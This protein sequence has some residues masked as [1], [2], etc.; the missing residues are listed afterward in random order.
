MTNR[1]PPRASPSVPAGRLRMGDPRRLLVLFLAARDHGRHRRRRAVGRG[2][3]LGWRSVLLGLL[4]HLV[5]ALIAFGHRASMVGG[6]GWPMLRQKTAAFHLLYSAALH[7]RRISMSQPQPDL[8]VVPR[9]LSPYRQG[10]TGIEYVHR[11]DS[12][13]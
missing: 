8:E 4:R 3:W 11:F 12:G 2:R 5:A 6:N 7:T 10:N 13:R 1:T 9:D